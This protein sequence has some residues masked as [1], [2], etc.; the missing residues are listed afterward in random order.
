MTTAFLA[1]PTV[2]RFATYFEWRAVH[3]EDF[4]IACPDCHGR[5]ITD[6]LPCRRCDTGGE[7][8]GEAAARAVY[9][10]QLEHEKALLRQIGWQP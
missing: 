1:V 8:D 7:L 6:G 2:L 9:H 10:Q 5:G 3:P 4:E